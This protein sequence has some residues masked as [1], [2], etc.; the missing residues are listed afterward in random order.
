MLTNDDVYDP[1]NYM[2]NPYGSDMLCS[3]S[4][5]LTT[6]NQHFMGMADQLVHTEEQSKAQVEHKFTRDLL[7]LESKRPTVPPVLPALG[8]TITSPLI[9]DNWRWALRNH[10]DR[11]LT[12][13][14]LEGIAH[15]FHIGFDR[16]HICRP[17]GSNMKSAIDN[18]RPVQ[19]YLDKE[20]AAGRIIGP[21][22]PQSV[23]GAQ[24][25]RFGVIPKSGQP[26]RW[27]LI[28]DLSSPKDGSVNAGIYRE[29]CSLSY[30]T[31]DDAV[32]KVLKVG[33]G[34][35]LAKVDIEHAYRNVPVHPDDRLL[36]AMQWA[37][38]IYL[39]TVL[40]F[41]LRSAPKIFSALADALEWI[42]L[43]AGVTMVLHYLDD[44]LTM[45][46]KGS[47]QCAHNLNL[48]KKICALLG[49][50]LKV[51]KIDGPTAVITFLG[52]LLDT[53]NLELRLPSEKMEEIKKLVQEWKSKRSCTQRELLS[54][55]GKLAHAA[56][57]VVPGRIF[58]R[59]MIDTAYSVRDL[60]HYVKLR[61]E[62][63]SDLAWWDCFMEGWNGKSM[64]EVHLHHR[65]SDYAFST[66]ASGNWGCGA[67]WNER[68]I[69]CPW[70]AY[71]SDKC[72][73]IKEM[74]PIVLACAIWGPHWRHKS[75]QVSCDNMSVVNVIRAN[76]SRDQTIM[77][78]LRCLHFFTAH[79]DIKLKAV[80]VAG[81]INTAADAISRNLM[82]VFFREVPNAQLQPEPVP[83]VLWELL[84]VQQ[85]DWISINWQA[86]LKTCVMQ[87]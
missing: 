53:Q 2:N 12:N 51:E 55:I 37:G 27:R 59:R 34:A 83:P 44:F 71:W 77:H 39:D 15:G 50:T 6:A 62:F 24:V 1:P 8:Y 32:E 43:Q 80:H 66:D 19:E 69:Q 70:L 25:S 31:V 29:I 46:Q 33:N 42:L 52:I 82:Q 7:E 30:P 4:N 38:K 79:F 57:V 67:Q 13:Y 86:L 60:D 20:L 81:A 56:K 45:G 48:M 75:V 9:V 3:S 47:D 16:R 73:A 63:H 49:F 35:L 78:L 74:L 18:P 54:L 23:Q 72:I 76:T 36:L 21:F 84:V 17:A 22:D 14:L 87:V 65:A 58:L 40:P 10:P 68:W 28:L 85:P 61:S 64:M 5:E 41:G 26:G 11:D